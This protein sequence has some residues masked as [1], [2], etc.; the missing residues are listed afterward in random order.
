[1]CGSASDRTRAISW[2]AVIA[3]FSGGGTS[4]RLLAIRRAARKRA[5]SPLVARMS[6]TTCGA[7]D[8]RAANS[9][10]SLSPFGVDGWGEGVT[11]DADDSEPPQPFRDVAKQAQPSPGGERARAAPARP[12]HVTQQS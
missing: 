10:R 11:G 2:G 6:E 4:L 7:A 9:V 8:E 1:M 3:D 12:R 5:T